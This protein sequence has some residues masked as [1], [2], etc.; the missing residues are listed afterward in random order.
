MVKNLYLIARGLRGKR[1][2]SK[3]TLIVLSCFYF[4]ILAYVGLLYEI[5]WLNNS[6]PAEILFGGYRSITPDMFSFIISFLFIVMFL[7]EIYWLN[8]QSETFFNEV[9]TNIL[10]VSDFS[11]RKLYTSYFMIR[12]VDLLKLNLL[13]TVPVF[14]LFGLRDGVLLLTLLLNIHILF[15]S[16]VLLLTLYD[17]SY[18][19]TKK[20]SSASIITLLL[21]VVIPLVNFVFHP[22]LEEYYREGIAT[23]LLHFLPDV[24]SI[25]YQYVLYSFDAAYSVTKIYYPLAFLFINLAVLFYLSKRMLVKFSSP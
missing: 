4:L 12:C 18:Y 6:F 7:V 13:F 2:S 20:S 5:I 25:G 9:T 23:T 24:L 3:A 16:S 22:L 15:F 1:T 11:G 19:L 14:L 21:I 10:K 17:I 8:L